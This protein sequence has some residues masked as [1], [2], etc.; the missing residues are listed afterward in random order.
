[1]DCLCVAGCEQFHYIR[2]AVADSAVGALTGLCVRQLARHT[3]IVEGLAR[4]MVSG[5]HLL[6]SPS[7]LIRVKYAEALKSLHHGFGNLL[8]TAV[9]TGS[10]R[11]YLC[12]QLGKHLAYH[13]KFC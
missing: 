10:Y 3:V 12:S 4:Y 2:L 13:R 1:M 5:A 8:N 6:V 7:I 11:L 9:N